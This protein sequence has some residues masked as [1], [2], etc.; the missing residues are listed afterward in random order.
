MNVRR[1][2]TLNERVDA[3][4][5]KVQLASIITALAMVLAGLVAIGT[6]P[7]AAAAATATDLSG[8]RVIAARSVGTGANAVVA[9]QAIGAYHFLLQKIDVGDP[10][11]SL[12]NCLPPVNDGS[13]LD[14]GSHFDPSYPNNCQWPGTRESNNLDEIVTQGTETDVS[15]VSGLQPGQYLISIRAQGFEVGGAHFTV[16][17]DPQSTFEAKLQPGPLPLATVRVRVY[18]DTAPVDGTYEIG[19]ED[20]VGRND[21][22]SAGAGFRGYLAD[23]LGDVST[24]FFGNPLCTEYEHY[25]AP[26]QDNP[27]PAY[28][29]DATN[30]A[31]TTVYDTTSGA[32]IISATNAGLG[33]LSNAD[34]DVVIPNMAP[35]RY[36]ITIR[37]PADKKSWFQTTTLEGATDHDWWVMANDTGYGQETTYGSEL[38]PEVQFGF[39][40]PTSTTSTGVPAAAHGS[41]SITGFEHEGCHYIGSP[42]GQVANGVPGVNGPETMDCGPIPNGVVAVSNLDLGDQ[43]VAT[44]KVSPADGA[45]SVDNLADGNYMVTFFDTAMNHILE[46][47][48]VTINGGISETMG[49]ALLSSWFAKIQGYV[50]IDN[51]GNG[52][53]DPGEPGVQGTTLTVRERDNTPMDQ[54]TNII[55]TDNAGHYTINQMYPLARYI[56]LEHVNSRY[57]PTGYTVQSCNDPQSHTYTG[58][59]VDISVLPVLGLCGSID[60]AVEPIPAGETGGIAGTV[61]YGT[62]RNELDA[63]QAATENWQPG[64]PNVPVHLFAPVICGTPLAL[65]PKYATQGQCS[66]S[67]ITNG[68]PMT[69]P[70]LTDPTTHDVVSG[71][72]LVHGP[73]LADP[74]LSETYHQPSGCTA[75]DRFGKPLVGQKALPAFGD[76]NLRCAES[77]MLGTQASPESGTEL[78]PGDVPAGDNGQSVNGNYGFTTSKLNLYAPTTDSN[79][80]TTTVDATGTEL[81]DDYGQPLEQYAPLD[82]STLGQH[83]SYPEQPLVP[84][85][86]IVSV[87]IPQD[88]VLHKPLYQVTKE[89][90]VNIFQGDQFAPQEDFPVADAAAGSTGGGVPGGAGLT[91]GLGVVSECAGP[92][93][94]VHV[95][96]PDFQ[97]GGGSP[98]EG[99][100]MPLCTDKLVDLKSG[101]T[102][103]TNFELFTEVPLATHFWGLTINDLGLQADPTSLG[104][105]EAEGLPH[106]PTGIYDWAG[107]LLDTAISDR[108]GFYEAVEP[109]TQRI[110]NPSPTGVSPGMYR[111]VGNDPG[112]PGHLNPQ[113]DP[114]YRTIATNFQAWPGL[115]TVTDT[116][117]TTAS[118]I[119]FTGG[120]QVLVKCDVPTGE[121]EL[122]SV[123][124]PEAT[125]GTSLKLTGKNFGS[126]GGSSAVLLGAPG[127]SVSDPNGWT[128]VP[129][130]FNGDGTIT[131]TLPA[132]SATF[133]PGP[134]QLLVVNQ[135]GQRSVLG[136][137]IH[138]TGTFGATSYNP[139][140]YNVGPNRTYATIQD[141]IDAAELALATDPLPLVVVYPGTPTS[142][143]GTPQGVTPRGEYAENLVLHTGIK[144]Q[145][146]G[147]G[148]TAADGSWVPGTIVTGEAFAEGSATGIAWGTTVLNAPYAGPTVVPDA[149]TIT[150]LAPRT[151]H[152]GD[153]T[154]SIDGMRITGGHEQ[155]QPGNVNVLTNGN[156]T[157]F[158]STGAVITQGGGIYVHAGTDGLQISNNLIEGNSG[159]YGGGIR[160]GTAFDGTITN[161]NMTI[162]HNR[163]D[164]NGGYN[165]AGGVGIYAGSTS[166][167]FSYNDVCGN[168]GGEYGG[169]V[170]HYG[171]SRHGSI[172]H[173]RVW[174]NESYDE[175]AGIMIAGELTSNPSDLS[176]GS[177][178]VTVK[179]NRIAQNIA[180]DDGGGVRLLM[181]GDWKI[182]IENNEIANNVSTHEGGGISLND[183]SNTVI[184]NNTIVGNVTTATAVTSN[185]RPA[186]AGLSLDR[187]SAMLQASLPASAPTFTNPT[188]FN[189]IFWDNRAGS[190]DGRSVTG[191]GNPGDTKN[192]WDIGAQDDQF[193]GSP[194]NSILNESTHSVSSPT[195]RVL[196]D[197]LFKNPYS[198][199]V[200][201]DARRAF[202]VFRQTAILDQTQSPWTT[203]NYELKT[204][205]PAIALGA[206]SKLG[207]GVVNPAPAVDITDYA[208]TGG[209]D[210][211]DWQFRTSTSVPQP[212]TGVVVKPANHG[213]IVSWTAPTDTGGLPLT[214]YT[215][216]VW[217]VN[218]GG[219]APLA[220]CTTAATTCTVTGLVNGNQY[221]VD[222]VATNSKGDSAPSSPRVS[223]IPANVPGAPTGVKVFPH[224]NSL[225]VTWVAP[226]SDGGATI[227][228]YTATARNSTGTTVRGTC[229]TAT[230][231]CTI[232]GLVNGQTSYVTV[233]ATNAVGN[234][235]R[236]APPVP[237]TPATVPGRPDQRSPLSAPL[238]VTARWDVGTTGFSPILSYT[239]RAWTAAS[240]GSV[241]R[242]CTT[243]DGTGRSC[244]IG[245]LVAGTTYWTDVV[246][247]NAIGTGLPSQPRRSQVAGA[248]TVPAAPTGVT[249]VP[250]NHQVALTWTAPANTGGTPIKDYRI[251]ASTDNGATW[252]TVVPNT[253]TSAT[254]FT[255]TGLV[256]L[257]AYRF[258]VAARNTNALTPGFGTNSA[259]SAIVTVGAPNAPTFVSAAGGRSCTNN[260]A[261]CGRITVTWIQGN[262]NGT[263][264]FSTTAR[265]YNTAT[266]GT[267]LGQCSAANLLVTC[268]ITGLNRNRVYWIDIRS[269]N[270]ALSPFSPRAQATAT[271]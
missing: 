257:Q 50:F 140:V 115:W 22:G 239:A 45:F 175:G 158:G 266:S 11:D 195:N 186:A 150:V 177:G 7:A 212:P 112:Q 253:P 62:T 32:P 249:G 9:G 233:V 21:T 206:A 40:P 182:G 124:T 110:N 49:T 88:K 120:S 183:A 208:R 54:F 6:T 116:A 204:G 41:A 108:N 144:V 161:T 200:I 42:G 211:G 8:L 80:V 76:A 90:D 28:P 216:R 265:A 73:E 68:K 155:D 43:L 46:T 191:I 69:V 171:L 197:P 85:D 148:G 86:Y 268:T 163:I 156:Q 203:G 100:P 113:Y 244:T 26:T 111:F 18:P 245:G 117:P 146:V 166:Y 79:G 184:D 242:S 149:A 246:A 2:L 152:T 5:R 106:V 94:T 220:T 119:T 254:S 30:R 218:S 10:N 224:P 136:V 38:V 98:F 87:D 92:Q 27:N 267:V 270:G 199:T 232:T 65:D 176:T 101:S 248:A 193:M 187:L 154:P 103:A 60:W 95:T 234:S 89:E 132:L 181:A 75:L 160:V 99:K 157:P 145:G 122:F 214:G 67:D 127:A 84:A 37:P 20:W 207:G 97:D 93:H 221:W 164:N 198:P 61:S 178:E 202:G 142:N 104:Y 24:D 130:T 31:G 105:D 33:C 25:V 256:N 44:T 83:Y 59:A 58:G 139:T 133:A 71:G 240:G 35:G 226:A 16:P 215:A 137:T 255:V 23:M 34:G 17:Y 129:A 213:L 223:G 185:G 196:A 168:F 169:G 162:A 231:T 247:T 229:S 53:R 159:T 262:N 114:R 4:D 260:N 143:V 109:S 1:S 227:T 237:G 192:L 128:N 19:A 263:A 13:Y 259:Q 147:P 271:T 51:N 55:D 222:V 56:V 172:D 190:Y 3:H 269:N 179:Q 225:E 96:D 165:L 228:S 47:Q 81:I 258:R 64:I 219:S 57:R 91:S 72:Q 78:L 210:A 236:S 174:F 209:I 15:H 138:V 205:S 39:I 264:I 29:A 66:S 36:G 153:A 251:Q 52:K 141:A 250:G 252:T 14:D 82:G 131:A 102:G 194:T 70:V 135:G 243:V 173:N 125:G 121:P 180:N 63:A 118:A 230:L 123:D 107:N 189:N 235:P 188:L 167:H 126:G 12:H 261:T 170:S 77:N 74:Y 241:V 201:V 217:D 48:N 238:G 134:R 151:H